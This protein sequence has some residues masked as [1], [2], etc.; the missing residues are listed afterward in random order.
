MIDF[1]ALDALVEVRGVTLHV[2]RVAHPHF[3]ALHGHDSDLHV[4]EVVSDRADARGRRADDGTG[5][6]PPG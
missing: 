6:L 2:N 5:L 3:T 1:E 4:A